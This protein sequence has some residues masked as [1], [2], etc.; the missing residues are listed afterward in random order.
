MA[1]RAIKQAYATYDSDP[2]AG[3]PDDRDAFVD[4]V[5]PLMPDR[6]VVDGLKLNPACRCTGCDGSCEEYENLRNDRME[7]WGDG[8]SKHESI[9]EYG[10]PGDSF[11]IYATPEGHIILELINQ[12]TT[13]IA[14]TTHFAEMMAND[15]FKAV[16]QLDPW[17][18]R[19]A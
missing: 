10:V 16:E 11:N 5:T 12:Q 15:L 18:S 8:M 3:G 13:R 2:R 17:D 19:D 1:E 7:R 4:A 6:A 9:T 14:M